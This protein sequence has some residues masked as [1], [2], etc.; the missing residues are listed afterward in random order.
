M[1]DQPIMLQSE[2]TKDTREFKLRK[3]IQVQTNC[4]VP[5]RFNKQIYN[6]L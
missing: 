4:Q 5:K 1:S 3:Q 2:T 6:N